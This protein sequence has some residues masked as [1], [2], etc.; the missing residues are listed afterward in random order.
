M[1]DQQ[2]RPADITVIGAGVIGVSAA[3]ALQTRGYDTTLLD[4]KGVAAGASFGNAGAFAFSDIVPLATPGIM[5][6]APKWLL[7]P[8]GPLSIPPSYALS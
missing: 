5:R 1:Y 8:L 2:S 3:L 6:S 4:R 7:D